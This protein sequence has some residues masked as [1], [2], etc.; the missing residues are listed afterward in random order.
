MGGWFWV[1]WDGEVFGGLSVGCVTSDY[2]LE[3]DLT[4]IRVIAL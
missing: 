4:Y 2:A 1:V 3:I